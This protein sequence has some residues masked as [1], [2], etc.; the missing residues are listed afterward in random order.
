MNLVAKEFVSARDD[1]RGVLVL[2]QFAGASRELAEALVVNPYD[3]DQCAAALHLALI[4]KPDEQRE[5]MR[6][7]R[8]VVREFNV[9]RWAGRMLLDAAV[10]RQRGRFRANENLGNR[11]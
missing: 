6:F 2:S 11:G 10:M 3:A 9:Y 1:E 8:G 7:M 5:R 4:M